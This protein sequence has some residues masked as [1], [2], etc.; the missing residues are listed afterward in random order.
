MGCG[1]PQYPC[2]KEGRDPVRKVLLATCFLDGALLSNAETPD[3][4]PPRLHWLSREG[5]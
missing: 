3:F 1:V 5:H 2:E 4:P